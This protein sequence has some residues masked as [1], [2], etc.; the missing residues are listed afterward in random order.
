MTRFV[1]TLETYFDCER[2]EN[3]FSG[4][5]SEDDEE[6]GEGKRIK[7]M[8]KLGKLIRIHSLN[9]RSNILSQVLLPSQA[10]LCLSYDLWQDIWRVPEFC[11][12]LTEN[13]WNDP[14]CILEATRHLHSRT[15]QRRT[16]IISL[17]WFWLQIIIIII[18]SC[19]CND[20]KSEE[21][22]IYTYLYIGEYVI[23]LYIMNESFTTFLSRISQSYNISA[24]IDKYW[25]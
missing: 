20:R 8:M 21:T 17:L 6:E 10:H 11:C 15:S 22:R 9:N 23:G 7:K 5:K 13:S 16:G 18:R 1:P 4:E 25:R 19:L 2:F 3:V 24:I 14:S 12:L